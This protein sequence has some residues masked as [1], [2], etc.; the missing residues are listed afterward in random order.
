MEASRTIAVACRA[1]LIHFRPFQTIRG[2][3]V[4][5]QTSAVN[6]SRRLEPRETLQ[7]TA[8]GDSLSAGFR[9]VDV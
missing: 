8:A 1:R 2:P 3:M 4:A 6:G 7:P 9:H 5:M